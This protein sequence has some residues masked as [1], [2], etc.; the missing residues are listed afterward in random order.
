[1][2]KFT[3]EEKRTMTITSLKKWGY[4]SP[5]THPGGIC[6][7]ESSISF[8]SHINNN[9]TGRLNMDYWYWKGP[10]HIQY[11]ISIV[12]THCHYGG[13][14]QWFICPLKRDGVPCMRLVGRL[15]ID[16]KY[17]GCRQCYRLAYK[18]Q[19]KARSGIQKLGYIV[20]DDD[21]ANQKIKR[22]RIK[23]W[24]GRATKRY[25]TLLKRSEKELGEL[26]RFNKQQLMLQKK[27]K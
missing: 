14:R 20:F 18:S 23:Y 9:N 26:I 11:A 12:A 22:L 10:E 13:T 17:F 27:Y 1:M 19:Y 21:A 7:T 25:K 3:C 2:G 4:L 16:G 6:W 15:Y 8:N 24:H 5:G